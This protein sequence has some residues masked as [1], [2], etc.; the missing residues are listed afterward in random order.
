VTATIAVPPVPLA[1]IGGRPVR[2][3]SGSNHT[4]RYAGSGAVTNAIPLAGRAEVDAAV[5]AAAQARSAWRASGPAG[6]RDLLNRVAAV[7]ERDA[8]ELTALSV[9]D[10]GTPITAARAMVATAA[11]HFRYAAGWADKLTGDTIPVWPQEAR[12]HTTIEPYGVVGIIVPW[13]APLVSAAMTIAPALAAGN[14]LVV[15]PPE[16]APYSISRLGELLQEAGAPPGLLNVCVGGPDGGDALVRDRRVS[17]IHFTGST[18]TARLILDAAL[19]HVVPVALELGGKSAHLVFADVPDLDAAL[20]HALGAVTQLSGQKCTAGTRLLVERSIYEPAVRRIAELC[21]EI[22]VGDPMAPETVMGPL[23]SETSVVRILG[24]VNRGVEN[25]EARLVAGGARLGGDL[26]AGY[27]MAPTVLADLPPDS[28]L[29]REE[30]FGPVLCMAPFDDELEAIEL[31]NDSSYG[32]GAWLQTA[33]VA[34]VLRVTDA[35]EVGQ[36]WVNGG[37]GSRAM[38]PFGGTKQS[39]FGRLGGLP[40]ILEFARTKSVWL[41]Y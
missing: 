23:A 12:A 8:A 35:L 5:G 33:D 28:A 27:F 14:T 15:K 31:A 34:R 25:G 21:R 30:I 3:T 13:N 41:E 40:G 38:V 1:M 37:S 29:W 17:K 10:N 9:I 39:G 18:A 22:R 11:D 6:R 36:V 7:I 16:A 4:H 19:E 32:L 24:Q 2:P 20:R 26:E